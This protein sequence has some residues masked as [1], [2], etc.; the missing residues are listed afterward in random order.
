MIDTRLPIAAIIYVMFLI[1]IVTK[2]SFWIEV[3]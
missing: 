1:T 3:I 2:I